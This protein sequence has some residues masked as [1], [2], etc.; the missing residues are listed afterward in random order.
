[1]TC[2]CGYQNEPDDFYCAQCGRKLSPGKK[3]GKGWMIAIVVILLLAAGAVAAWF[4]IPRGESPDEPEETS[5]QTLAEEES[6]DPQAVKP[7]DV[8]D[9]EVQTPPANGWD[10]D[11]LYYYVDSEAVKGLQTIDGKYYYF[12]PETGE[13]QTG[14]IEID[15]AWHFFT[16]EGPA[17][18]A[19][20]YSDDKG[21]FY[22]EED[23]KHHTES[24]FVNEETKQEY[25]LDEDG[26]L[27][28]MEYYELVCIETN[29]D[30]NGRA[31]PVLMVP[32]TLT[33]CT[34]LTFHQKEASSLTPVEG[35]IWEIWLRSGDE[36]VKIPETPVS[37]EEGCYTLAFTHPQTFDAICIFTS[38][39][40]RISSTLTSVTVDY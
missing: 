14:W 16:E 7:E 22:L 37:T 9:P 8:K 31:R 18:G 13:K 6:Q 5:E 26:Y 25:I 4:L 2:R 32:G 12:D 39:D 28:R 1:M 27:T 34:E 29:E 23:G 24:P 20:W 15:E 3:G 10:Q 36:W 33:N 35:A 17:P 38:Q 40:M 30:V 11:R 21:W 19:G